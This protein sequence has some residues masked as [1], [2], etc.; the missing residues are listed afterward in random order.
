MAGTFDLSARITADASGL[1]QAGAQ[2]E[3][4][5]DGLEK[6]QRDAA[7]AARELEA[8]TEGATKAQDEQTRSEK[9]ST[10]AHDEAARAS[11]RATQETLAET[12]AR[13]RAA[14]AAIDTAAAEARLANAQSAA[15]RSAAA[16]ALASLRLQQAQT[17]QSATTTQLD[18][19]IA[20]LRAEL[21]PAGEAQ[22]QLAQ[23]IDIANTALARGAITQDQYNKR[24]HDLNS[25]GKLSADQLNRQSYAVR[26][27]GQQFGDL[28]TQVALGGGFARAFASQAGQMG[29]ALS[30]FGGRLGKVGAFLVGPWGIALTTAAVLAAPF[31]GSLFEAKKGAEQVEV[32]SSALATAQGALGDIFD[33]TTGKLKG[34]NSELAAS[35]ELLRI[36]ARLTAIN[37][38]VEAAKN[39]NSSRETF[40][41]AGTIGLKGRVEGFGAGFAQGGMTGGV[42]GAITGSERG[43]QNVKNIRS[44]VAGIRSGAI[45]SEDALQAAE[46]VDFTGTGVDREQFLGAI[47]D[48]V[49]AD[50]NKEVAALIDKSLDQGTLSTGL[51]R[52]AT[53][54]K[55]P[56]PKSTA[57]R[58]EFGR[59]TADKLAGLRESLSDTPSVV[60]QVN[61]QIRQLDDLIDDLARK[62]PPNFEK[63]IADAKALKPLVL[64]SL[65]K[66]FREY[67]K[68]QTES[69][70]VGALTLQ[71]RVDEAAA[72]KT[73]QQLQATMRPLTDAQKAAVLATTEAMRAQARAIDDLRQRNAKYV[74]AVGGIKTVVE[75]ATQAFVRGDLGQLLKSP[76]KLLDAFQT[77]QGRK[78][79]DSLFGEA[80]RDLEDQANGTAVVKDASDRMAKA[81]DVANTSIVALGNAAQ[82]TAQRLAGGG[83]TGDGFALAQAA[84]SSGKATSAGDLSTLLAGYKGPTGPG[85][86]AAGTSVITGRRDPIVS[87]LTKVGEKISGL[88]TNPDNAKKIGA[89]I[90]TFAGKGLAGAATGSVVSGIG[91]ALG[92]KMSSTGAQIGGAIG[93]FIPIPG[94][95]IIG[96]IAGGLIGNLFGGSK[97]TGAAVLRNASDAATVS[98]KLGDAAG[99]TAKSVQSGL[100]QIANALGAELG[101]FNVSIGKREDYF[102]VS[103]TGSSKVGDKH[104]GSAGL[105]YNGTDE[106]QAIAIAIR[107]AITDGGV[108]GLSAAVQQALASN[109]DIDKAVAEAVKVKN[110]ETLIAGVGGSLKA[111]FTALDKE[112]AERVTLARKYGLDL[113]AV[114]R[115]NGEQRAALV[116]DALKSRIGSLSDFLDQLKFGGLAEGSASEK[117]NALLE[118]IKTVQADAE[119]GKDGAASQLAQLYT[120]L[121]TNSRSDFGTAGGEYTSDRTSSQTAVERVI[122]METKRVNEAAGAQATT[123][124]VK[125]VA[126]GVDETNDL[127]AQMIAQQRATNGYL[128]SGGYTGGGGVDYGVTARS[129]NLQ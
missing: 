90:G 33:L 121:V 42:L 104:P 109:S 64:D 2:G 87:S 61:T 57:A 93:N 86:D 126:A 30:E 96:S 35:N 113:L 46:K 24:L 27:L 50:A 60:R 123:D 101:D 83:G 26:N 4:A 105:I 119:A 7:A 63:L 106:G 37:L 69:L 3:A 73:V 79:F 111:Q 55:P 59:D 91:K 62:K 48:R 23:N 14:K 95:S 77:L 108:K 20:A 110:L 76:G 43:G 52:T 25:T 47:R 97:P 129:V 44:V 56:K 102:R 103:S 13:E 74:E 84:L 98:G 115:I 100:Q 58:D 82:T 116:D 45:K 51:R 120:Q 40:D 22:R 9:A 88:F 53:P 17:R 99:G 80:F 5:Y 6:A 34:L 89:S 8:A 28:G 1:V 72:L 39:A 54:K 78:I 92:I 118:K 71:G 49:A 19:D 15:E 127:L 122:A 12:I 85:S 31:I 16:A 36:N 65:N 68:A 112:A 67:L 124:A 94:G 81:V 70:A 38:R 21:D 18:R 117:R 114:E 66:P 32:A 10:A 125:S 29:Y 75:D 107:D 41:K 128:A 11:R